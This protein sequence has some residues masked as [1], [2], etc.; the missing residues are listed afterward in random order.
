MNITQTFSFKAQNS[1]KY[2]YDISN[3]GLVYRPPDDEETTIKW[4]DIDYLQD[5]PYRR[6]DVHFQNDEDPIPIYYD[7]GRFVILLRTIC[8]KLAA[9]HSELLPGHEFTASMGYF[10]HIIATISFSALIIIFG[11]ENDSKLLLMV[12]V[13]FLILAIHLMKRP[14]RISF[15]EENFIIK[16]LFFKKTF[17]YSDISDLDFSLT[18]HEYSTYLV[19]NIHLKNGKKLKIQR[20]KD[21]TL[22]YIYLTSKYKSS[23]THR[24]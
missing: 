18:G 11:I 24:P 9:V 12:S 23:L 10:F 15:S 4:E 3:E 7:T 6:V 2:Y 20:L 21:I 22:C 1:K 8:D 16:D 14:L 5:S 13:L 19:I 17:G